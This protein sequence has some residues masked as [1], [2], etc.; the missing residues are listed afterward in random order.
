MKGSYT[1]GN[2][3]SV[4]AGAVVGMMGDNISNCTVTLG[5]DNHVIDNAEDFAKYLQTR[6][7]KGKSGKRKNDK[8]ERA[9]KTYKGFLCDMTLTEC[10]TVDNPLRG[11]WNTIMQEMEEA[12]EFWSLFNAKFSIVTDS[13]ELVEFASMPREAMEM[14]LEERDVAH[15]RQDKT[16]RLLD[17]LGEIEEVATEAA[18][19]GLDLDL[20]TSAI[21]AM[22]KKIETQ[23]SARKESGS[24]TIKGSGALKKWAKEHKLMQLQSK[25]GKSFMAVLVAIEVKEPADLEFLT[26]DALRDYYAPVPI[27]KI[28][29]ARRSFMHAHEEMFP[30][31]L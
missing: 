12:G 31:A 25:T 17:A 11:R 21:A 4:P 9:R 24:T 2:T 3:Y 29:K 22:R 28:L 19:G 13:E 6:K 20:L 14:L 18:S 30:D 23:D 8:R 10:L 7:N 27:G 15:Q 26:R 5:S 1:G 16:Y